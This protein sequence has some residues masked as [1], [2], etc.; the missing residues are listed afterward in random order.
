MAKGYRNAVV[1]ESK[2]GVVNHRNQLSDAEFLFRQKYVTFQI[3]S[4]QLQLYWRNHRFPLQ[5]W[6]LHIAQKWLVFAKKSSIQ[7]WPWEFLTRIANC[8]NYRKNCFRHGIVIYKKAL[9][10][11]HL[12]VSNFIKVERK[13]D[14]R[15]GAAILAHA[16]IS[17]KM[18]LHSKYGFLMTLNNVTVFNLQIRALA[19]VFNALAVAALAALAVAG[20]VELV[21]GSAMAHVQHL[22]LPVDHI[23]GCVWSKLSSKQSSVTTSSLSLESGAMV[24]VVARTSLSEVTSPSKKVE[25]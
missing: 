19:F 1:D 6:L 3:E 15:T 22:W 10:V 13:F 12:L 25:T 18:L 4:L 5:L 21:A 11:I 7:S 23:W 17:P 2:K 16:N 14:R 24:S 9:W 8:T 20:V